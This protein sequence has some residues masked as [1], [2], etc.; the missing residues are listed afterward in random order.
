VI[1]FDSQAPT[2]PNIDASICVDKFG[3]LLAIVGILLPLLQSFT[4]ESSSSQRVEEG[5]V[6][7]TR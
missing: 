7:F 5:A 4:L 1:S 6:N 3:L 2:K